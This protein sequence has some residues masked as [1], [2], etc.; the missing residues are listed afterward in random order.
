MEKNTKNGSSCVCGCSEHNHHNAWWKLIKVFMACLVL[1]LTLLVGMAVGRKSLL[2]EGNLGYHGMMNLGNSGVMMRQSG[3]LPANMLYLSAGSGNASATVQPSPAA[4]QKIEPGS[5]RV[6]GVITDIT[7]TAITILDNG[8]NSE[9]VY[10]T[11]TTDI[12]S[13]TKEVPLSSLKAKNFIVSYVVTKN[14]QEVAERIE[15]SQ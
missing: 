12:Y 8:G 5:K 1:L 14:N 11:S 3:S 13:G 9:T 4:I 7:G 2:M 15:V 10:S 6:A